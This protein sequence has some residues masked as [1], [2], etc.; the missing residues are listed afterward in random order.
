ME[1]PHKIIKKWVVKK[2]LK[3]I[4]MV[5][6]KM[7]KK[8]WNNQKKRK[9]REKIRKKRKCGLRRDLIRGRIWKKGRTFT[10]ATFLEFVLVAD[11]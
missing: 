7:K 10:G 3:L 8:T 4:I 6:I 9:A 11:V 2:H 5:E 1:E